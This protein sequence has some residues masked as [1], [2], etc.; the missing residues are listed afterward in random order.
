MNVIIY[1]TDKPRQ[2]IQVYPEKRKEVKK[3]QPDAVSW[4]ETKGNVSVYH[5]RVAEGKYVDVPAVGC[6]EYEDYKNIAEEVKKHFN[7][8]VVYVEMF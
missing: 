2:G 1:L 4:L 3:Y 6:Y 5:I 8:D 7:K